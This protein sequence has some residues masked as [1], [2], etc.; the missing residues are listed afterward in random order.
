MALAAMVVVA[1]GAQLE[2]AA[3]FP[4]IM[5]TGA[6]YFAP[7]L[8]D[9][10][11]TGGADGFWTTVVTTGSNT[12][13]NNQHHAAGGGRAFGVIAT[14]PETAA[15]FARPA[16][17]GVYY[18]YQLWRVSHCDQPNNNRTAVA[19]RGVKG[20][21]WTFTV[22]PGGHEPPSDESGAGGVR[23]CKGPVA[24]AIVLGVVLAML[25]AAAAAAAMVIHKRRAEVSGS[26]AVLRAPDGAVDLSAEVLRLVAANELR[27]A[28]IKPPLPPAPELDRTNVALTEQL[29][30]H[31]FGEL[32]KGVLSGPRDADPVPVL[33]EV[34][35]SRRT[36]EVQSALARE[37]AIMAEF[38]AAP[39][40]VVLHGIVSR[41][42]PMMLLMEWCEHGKLERALRARADGASPLH[43]LSDHK[44]A[45]SVASA[46]LHLASHKFVHGGLTVGVVLVTSGLQ[47]K[48]ADFGSG[49]PPALRWPAP[50]VLLC[51]K[52]STA[53]DVYAF[54]NFLL[55]VVLNG[56]DPYP[57][58]SQS[59]AA[60]KVMA[61]FLPPRPV[62]CSEAMY[63]L[64]L[65][66]W[67]RDSA[68]RPEFPEVLSRIEALR[69]AG[70]PKDSASPSVPGGTKRR[71]L[72]LEAVAA[73]AAA[74]RP[75]HGESKVTSAP[76]M[77]TE[78]PRKQPAKEFSPA[79]HAAQ[80]PSRPE[81]SNQR[82]AIG[83]LRT[84][85]PQIP[86]AGGKATRS[87]PRARQ[88]QSV[89][90]TGHKQRSAVTDPGDEALPPLPP[91]AFAPAD[92]KKARNQKKRL[93]NTKKESKR[94][95]ASDDG[96][97]QK[98]SRVKSIERPVLDST[99]DNHF[100][101]DL[102]KSI[103][104]A[105][106][107]DADLDYRV[108]LSGQDSESWPYARPDPIVP[109]FVE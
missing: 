86:G 4:D 6:T 22:L 109:R 107:E 93:V 26:R 25:L 9:P 100:A 19:E 90:A 78:P 30:K 71:S 51:S 66:C 98:S 17:P 43:A 29:G 49:R 41:S 101:R 57:A 108:P 7:P 31:R 2:R 18:A 84:S 76:P 83:D 59:D 53:S 95:A 16:N 77:N 24:A 104:I 80:K 45:T 12:G 103:L 87:R 96:S 8:Q 34:A 23:D 48:I 82:T 81:H 5:T 40:I 73:A 69:E 68:R 32:W 92:K 99:E 11:S 63:G 21:E 20:R 88:S 60:A 1:A 102:Q 46:M 35:A 56:A 27:R 14:D 67:H 97:H 79:P 52:Y 94:N 70:T 91:S 10:G 13:G 37:A 28:S 44:I 47:C 3:G 58:L 106:V 55:A 38:G 89:E 54:G 65:D 72:W 64:M 74:R 62:R 75:S 50:E 42:G 39:G 36:R 15:A 33:V 85:S 61:G 105:S